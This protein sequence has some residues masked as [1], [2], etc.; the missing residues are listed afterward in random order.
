LGPVSN[1]IITGGSNGQVLTTNG[2]G[3]LSWT[4]IT[5]GGGGASISNG[6]SNVNIPSANGNVTI[7]VAGN[8]NIATFTGTGVN[9]SGTLNVTGNANVGNIGATGVVAT[10]VSGSLTTASQPN[11]TSVGTLTSLDVSGNVSA[12]NAN[13]GN[14]VSANFFTGNGVYLTGIT[15]SGVSN[16]NSN[17]NIPAANGNV[18]ISAVGNANVLVVTGTGANVT[19]TANVTGNIAGGGNLNIA[20]NAVFGGNLTVDGN[21]VYVNVTDLSVEDPIIQLQTGPNAAPPTSNTGK[22]VGV[23]LNYYDT[24]AKIAFMGWDVSNAEIAFG[25]NVGISSEVVSFTSLAN[26]RSGNAQLGNLATANFVAG[27]L[28]TA[29]QPNITTIGT[30]SSLSVTGNVTA[31]NANLGNTVSANFFTG[32]GSLLTG[33][34]INNLSNGNSNINIPAANGNVNISSAGNANI[35]VVTG[36]GANVTGNFSVS[37]YTRG[38]I[39]SPVGFFGSNIASNPALVIQHLSP[40]AYSTIDFWSSSNTYLGAIGGA[41]PS[42]TS[43][44]VGN[45]MTVYSG[46][47]S[48]NGVALY[49]VTG[50]ISLSPSSTSNVFVAT[51]TGVNVTG[52]LNATGNANVGNIGATGGVFTTVAGS[53][54]TAAQPNIT[55]IGTLGSLAVTGNITAGNANLGNAV[56]ANFFVGNGSL[57]TGLPGGTNI[58]NGNS[59][60]NIPAANGNVNISA[61]GNANI[62]VVTG[63]GANITGT[64]NITGNAN[65]GNL[66]TTGL[67]V[68]GT[69]NL[70]PVGNVTITGGSN[71]QVLTTNGTGGLS[72][73]TVSGGG[74]GGGANISNGNSNVNIA[75]ANGNITMGVAGN[76]NIV[77]VTGTGVNVAGTLNVTGN[78]TFGAKSNLGPVGNV[79]IT[80]GSSGQYLRTDGAGNLSW[81]AT[82][83]ANGNVIV[84]TFTGTGSQTNFT[85]SV[86]P[87]SENF[88]LVNIDG[89]L[90]LH[91]AYTVS[92]TTLTF[93][94]APTNG[95][96]IEVQIWNLTGIGG[97][98]YSGNY[99][100]S[101]FTANGVQNTTTVTN[102]MTVD[103]VIVTFDGVVQT[104]TTD[105]TISGTTM[106]FTTAPGNGV[107][108]QVRELATGTNPQ[109]ALNSYTGDNTTVNFSIA[110][111]ATA[112]NT[113]VTLN[114]VLQTPNVDYTVSGSTLT[115]TSAPSS[116]QAILFREL[117]GNSGGGS[118]GGASNARVTGYSLVFG[119]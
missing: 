27:T 59:N 12:G 119:G 54:T 66:G 55:S 73:T 81:A 62:L 68:A 95:S 57:L 76:A 4:T 111:G 41:N 18:N 25:A 19:G 8:S 97:S 88:I 63:T 82:V 80:G 46:T 35:L 118:G 72:W 39:G 98:V 115:F 49:A 34:T 28:T 74:G 102:G 40:T 109:F 47:A 71:G 116:G 15:T 24:S 7:S 13:L 93:D 75:T 29:S 11:I 107:L 17:V 10:T 14:N 96:N 30:L 113:L 58:A 50:N 94:A 2:S 45:A 26:I 117:K 43:V 77:T 106:T 70:G 112:A 37:S 42:A 31:G 90:Q 105:Y 38:S 84:D 79:I 89:V 9:V 32:N 85:L 86:T 92:G 16:G 56:T 67:L 108:V 5:G 51:S 33:I 23:A 104:P 114:G 20:G 69:S 87:T 44:P 91:N 22:D 36:T 3:N 78:A 83:G 64:A 21:L 110:S 60:V 103:T 52:T 6:N 53:L 100:T 48:S 1:V 99:S 101:T 65:V 61:A